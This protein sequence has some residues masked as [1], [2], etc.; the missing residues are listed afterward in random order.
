MPKTN[1]DD[2]LRLRIRQ[3]VIALV[4]DGHGCR[5]RIAERIQR[6]AGRA[7]IATHQIQRE[8]LRHVVLRAQSTPCTSPPRVKL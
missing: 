8:A 6:D 7:L 4:A 3:V 5:D 2:R 1:T